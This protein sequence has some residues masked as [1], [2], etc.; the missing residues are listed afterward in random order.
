ME[1]V[2]LAVAFSI[3]VLAAIAGVRHAIERRVHLVSTRMTMRSVPPF[4][5]GNSTAAP[6]TATAI[7]DD[8]WL[9]TGEQA[10]VAW[11]PMAAE[12]PV[13]GGEWSEPQSRA[14]TKPLAAEEQWDAGLALPDEPDD[15]PASARHPDA[16][17]FVENGAA[18]GTAKNDAERPQSEPFDASRWLF[19]QGD[20]ERP[21]PL[22]APP[23][24]EP[25]QPPHTD[26]GHPVPALGPDPSPAVS[27]LLTAL[28]EAT[29]GAGLSDQSRKRAIIAYCRELHEPGLAE[30][31]VSQS[32]AR[33]VRPN[34]HQEL[35]RITRETVARHAS[36]ELAPSPLGLRAAAREDGCPSMAVLLLEAGDDRINAK[37]ASER[38]QHR[39][40]CLRCQALILRLDRAE[41]AFATELRLSETL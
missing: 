40:D 21:A 5:S 1:P 3:V 8:V 41:R 11:K 20:A 32:L 37:E 7:P 25:S 27:S 23:E 2:V 6:P 13:V 31:V 12:P 24:N 14:S 30:K 33:A 9:S 28:A 38:K 18:R 17:N 10:M 29:S 35:L 15:E 19:S 36:G 39:R 4:R 22:A 16:P 34:D 26:A